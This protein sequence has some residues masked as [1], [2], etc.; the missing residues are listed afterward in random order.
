MNIPTTEELIE[1]KKREEF[2]D[3]EHKSNLKSITS[4][5]LINFKE[6]H[7]KDFIKYWS[8]GGR[9]FPK[10]QPVSVKEFIERLRNKGFFKKYGRLKK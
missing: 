9:D 3:L 7:D 2:S 6:K 5:E 4:E 8:A 1:M 10:F